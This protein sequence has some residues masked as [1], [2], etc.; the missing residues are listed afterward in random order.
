MQNEDDY[1]KNTNKNRVISEIIR[2]FDQFGAYLCQ[3]AI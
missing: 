1:T 2:E 3:S